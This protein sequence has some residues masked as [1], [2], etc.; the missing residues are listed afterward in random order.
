MLK[1][2]STAVINRPVEDVFAVLSNLEN[3]PKWSSAF[4]EVK[5][6][7]D[8]PIAVGTTWR[9]VQKVFGQGLESEVEVTEYEP[10]RKWTQK[11]KSP[12]L[13]QVRTTFESVDG[14]TQVNLR[15]EGE[16]GGFFK[17]AEPLV[18]MMAK[19]GIEGDLANLKDLMEAH[20]L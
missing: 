16:P 3:N 1:I 12:F 7:S 15:L 6:T 18:A 10:N 14:G 20:A 2:E 4:L 19:R 8:G 11:G 9:A 5:K 17:L 13:V